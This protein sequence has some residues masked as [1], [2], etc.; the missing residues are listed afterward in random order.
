MFRRDD[1]EAVDPEAG[2][3]A[4]AAWLSYVGGY[5]GSKARS[6]EELGPGEAAILKVDGDNVAAYRDESGTLHAVSAVCT[7]MGCL[8]GWNQTDKTWDCP[9]HGSRFE[10]SGEVVHGPATRPLG[11]KITG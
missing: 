1:G 11:S 2:L 7:H 6:Y 10:L 8:V 9:C 4:R 5:L 3:A